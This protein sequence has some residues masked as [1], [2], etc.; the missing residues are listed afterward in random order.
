M[1]KKPPEDRETG[2]VLLLEA[3]TELPENNAGTQRNSNLHYVTI[4][5]TSL[6]LNVQFLLVFPIK[7]ENARNI[8]ITLLKIVYRP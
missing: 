6:T 5:M 3:G 2:I 7:T 4:L 1:L 8:N